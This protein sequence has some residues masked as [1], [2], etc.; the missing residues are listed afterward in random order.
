MDLTFQ[1]PMQNLSLQHQILLSSPDTP[2]TYHHFSFGSAA[3]FF[4]ELLVAVLHSS[5]VTYQ[6]PS[7]LGGSSF[8][9][10][11]FYAAHGFSQNTFWSGLPVSPPVDHILSE[12]STVT[13]PSWLAL[14]GGA[15][16][17]IDLCKPL[18][19]DNAVIYEVSS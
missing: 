19:H 4:L 17:F 12:L 3:S 8:G 7:D 5:P 18:F 2:T 16:S 9:V 10:I 14:N 6:T 11:P 13:R 1:V 15:H